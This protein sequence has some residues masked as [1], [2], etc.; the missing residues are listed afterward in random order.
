MDAMITGV[1]GFIGSTLADELTR[2]G[3]QVIGVDSFTSYYNPAQKWRN[4]A[5][6]L[7]R[8]NF[9]L[10]D[11]N[12]VDTAI[13]DCVSDVDAVFHLAGQPGVRGSWADGFDAYADA[14]VVATQRVLEA[15]RRCR[16]P[17]VVY[18]SSSSVYGNARRYPCTEDDPL[19]PYSPYGVTKLAGEHLCKLYA[20]NYGIPTVSLRYFTVFGPRQRPEMAMAQLIEAA[21]TG[22]PFRL[23]AAPEAVRDFTYVGDV[24]QATIAAGLVADIPPSTVLNV[25]GGTPATMSEVIETVG[26]LVGSPVPIRAVAPQ[27][28]D[29][30]RTGGDNSRARRL[31]QW[32]PRV[33]LRAGLARQVEWHLARRQPQMITLPPLSLPARVAHLHQLDEVAI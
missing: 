5:A 18:A 12:L 29:V 33:T 13:E 28:G 2:L 10:V 1:A 15:A 30:V 9:E 4:V 8:D 7:A 23:F 16:T 24:V 22:E 31:L 19:A 27:A 11:A 3:H 17:R 20:H 25:A 6:L 21:L 26:G 32:S 14:N